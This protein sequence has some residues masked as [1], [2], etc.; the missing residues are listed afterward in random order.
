[1]V[2]SKDEGPYIFNLHKLWTKKELTLYL[3]EKFAVKRQEEKRLME[4]AKQA[5]KAQVEAEHDKKNWGSW[6]TLGRDGGEGCSSGSRMSH[7]RK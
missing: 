1:M 6:L 3:I 7:G 2:T 4:E 5:R